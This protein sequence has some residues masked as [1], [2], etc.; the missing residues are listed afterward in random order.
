MWLVEQPERGT[1]RQQRGQGDPA[2]L[3]GRQPAGRRRPQ[4]P[5]QSEALERR[6]GALHRQAESPHGELDVFRRAELVVE[7]GGMPEKPHVTTHR[8]VIGGQVDAEDGGGA[9][10]HRQQSGTGPQ[11]T[12]L[13]GTVGAHDDDHLTLVER[14][15]DPGKG[16]E[17]AGERDRGT[18]VNDRGHGLPHHGRGGGY[19]GSK[20]GSG[21][22]SAG[23]ELGG[24]PTPEPSSP[25]S[26][27]AA[28]IGPQAGSALVGRVG[29]PP[30]S[31][32]RP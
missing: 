11:E 8:G 21:R 12:G 3:P 13:A 4:T 14:Q 31:V 2:P 23:A 28:S 17:A 29:A 16:R 25:L 27:A 30:G 22:R 24:I 15:I 32:C 10:R 26:W 19:Q 18:K 9:R 6:V 1:A 7:G 5:G 20:R